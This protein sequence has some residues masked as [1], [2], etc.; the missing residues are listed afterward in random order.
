LQVVRKMIKGEKIEA[1]G[2][3]SR[4]EWDGLLKLLS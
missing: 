3:L 2:G 1:N 4:S